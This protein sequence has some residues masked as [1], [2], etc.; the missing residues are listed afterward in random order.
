VYL[1]A[2][3]VT[4]VNLSVLHLSSKYVWVITVYVTRGSVCTPLWD[5]K[6][7]AFSL[8][9]DCIH[10]GP[11][12]SHTELFVVQRTPQFSDIYLMSTDDIKSLL[13]RGRRVANPDPT[14]QE[15]RPTM[16]GKWE[17][18]R[19]MWTSV[20]L[21]HSEKHANFSQDF[22]TDVLRLGGGEDI[23]PLVSLEPASKLVI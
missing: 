10:A 6:C 16:E 8:N 7:D 17:G 15:N 11:C 14:G 19:H 3:N 4:G 5:R 22:Q 12:L 2:I 23:S 9:G 18:N 1:H 20:T 13:T 21:S